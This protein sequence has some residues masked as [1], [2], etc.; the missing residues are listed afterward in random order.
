MMKE[1]GLRVVAVNPKHYQIDGIKCYASVFDLPSE[2]E[3]VVVVVPPAQTEKV[4]HACVK[5]GI[6]AVWL[7]RGAES[8][9]A[10][11]EAEQGGISVI[12]GQ[13]IIMFLEPVQGFHSVH[14]FFTKLVGAYPH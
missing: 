14:R 2:V 8:P 5:K 7:Q 1:K 3:S 10:I 4:V 9:R 13:C 11:E 6:P 12:Q